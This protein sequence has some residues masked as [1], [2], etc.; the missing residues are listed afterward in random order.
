MGI[1][2]ASLEKLKILW[3]GSCCWG[4]LGAGE[5]LGLRYVLSYVE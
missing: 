1:S 5:D 2:D 3:K 4:R